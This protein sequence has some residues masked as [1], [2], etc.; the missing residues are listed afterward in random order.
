[1]VC[2]VWKADIRPNGPALPRRGHL[3]D[4]YESLRDDEIGIFAQDGGSISM[5]RHPS[6]RSTGIRNQNAA[7]RCNRIR[8]KI[9]LCLPSSVACFL[10]R[11]VL[12]Y[13]SFGEQS[14]TTPVKI[15]SNPIDD[16][17]RQIQH[18]EGEIDAHSREI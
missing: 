1:M 11:R 9:N 3:P 18:E 7:H 16:C 13:V 8:K 6:S 14:V 15:H 10:T 5:Q 12:R 4:V 17:V 2:V